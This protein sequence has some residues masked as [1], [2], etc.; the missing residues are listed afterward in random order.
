MNA[1]HPPGNEPT[2][3]TRLAR[4][5]GAGSTTSARPR[6]GRGGGL[7]LRSDECPE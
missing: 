5:A 1:A 3:E 2:T 6:R 4:A 7:S